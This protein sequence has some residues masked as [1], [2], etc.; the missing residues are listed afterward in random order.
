MGLIGL[1]EVCGVV[2][3]LGPEEALFSLSCRDHSDLGGD[4]EDRRGEMEL[5]FCTMGWDSLHQVV[6]YVT[7]AEMQSINQSIGY[8]M[9]SVP[10]AHGLAAV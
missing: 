2:L 7:L 10:R 5:S 4:L 8:S 9:Y 6:F 3:L 1:R